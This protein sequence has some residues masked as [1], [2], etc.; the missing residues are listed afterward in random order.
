MDDLD[1]LPRPRGH[2]WSCGSITPEQVQ[3]AADNEPGMAE[4]LEAVLIVGDWVKDERGMLQLFRIPPALALAVIRVVE[5][6]GKMPEENPLAVASRIMG[7][8]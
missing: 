6:C 2:N 5:S 1:R 7:L 4:K 3:A 8:P